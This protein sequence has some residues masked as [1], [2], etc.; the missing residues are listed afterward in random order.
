MF[1][2]LLLNG[3]PYYLIKSQHALVWMTISW[4]KD[5]TMLRKYSKGN[6]VVSG[7]KINKLNRFCFLNIEFTS[8]KPCIMQINR[9]FCIYKIYFQNGWLNKMPCYTDYR[10]NLLKETHFHHCRWQRLF[11]IIYLSCKLLSILLVSVL[12]S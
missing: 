5:Q 7:K 4:K 11:S 10:L 9:T 6:D 12:C 3:N 8:Q 2:S 1:V